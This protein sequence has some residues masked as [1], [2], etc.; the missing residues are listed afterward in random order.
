MRPRSGA[1]SFGEDT[2][3]VTFRTG[4]SG[5]AELHSEQSVIARL[6]AANGPPNISTPY[7]DPRAFCGCRASQC[8]PRNGPDEGLFA[9]HLLIE[10]EGNSRRADRLGNKNT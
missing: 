1:T 3:I 4:V 2:K 5:M 8:E 9:R 7:T 6:G 10:T